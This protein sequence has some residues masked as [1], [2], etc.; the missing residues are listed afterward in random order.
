MR[1]AIA[2]F[3]VTL[4]AGCPVNVPAMS[5]ACHPARVM[6]GRCDRTWAPGSLSPVIACSAHRQLFAMVP[7]GVFTVATFA[8][9]KLGPAQP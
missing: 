2:T 5:P 9:A 7:A 3:P 6:L 1:H 8:P 4:P